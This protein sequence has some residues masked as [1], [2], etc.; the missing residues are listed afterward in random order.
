VGHAPAL[1][2]HLHRGNTPDSARNFTDCSSSTDEEVLPASRKN[3]D[4]QTLSTYVVWIAYTSETT[5][6][7][8]GQQ[9]SPQRSI[10]EIACIYLIFHSNVV[11]RTI[12]TVCATAAY[13]RR[14]RSRLCLWWSYF[15]SV[16]IMH[17]NNSED[18]IHA[19]Q[20][21]HLVI[22]DTMISQWLP[23][24]ELQWR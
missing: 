23:W 8:N 18:R 22:F 16:A 1:M 5:A 9:T 21:A 11:A 3:L 17:K 20:G 7:S 24:Y 10:H 4:V 15:V 2:G 14:Y 13:K 19:N 12:I 6:K